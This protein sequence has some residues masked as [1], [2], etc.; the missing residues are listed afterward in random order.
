[1]T[2]RKADDNEKFSGLAFK[3]MTDPFV[4]SL[5]FVRVYSGVLNSGSYVQNTIK[6][7]RERVGR[8]LLMHA[9]SREDVKEAYAGDIVALAGLKNTT[10]GDTICD[11]DHQVILERM[12]FPEPVIEVAVE[13]EN[14]GRPGKNGR[15]PVAPRFG[16]SVIAPLYK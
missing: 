2:T 11:V 15:R 12:E 3:I 9:N 4:G 14:Q 13:P 16:R 8:M 10:T 5:T 1:M 7:N 6:D